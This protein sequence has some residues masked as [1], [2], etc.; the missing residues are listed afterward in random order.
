VSRLTEERILLD[1]ARQALI[2]GEPERSLG[3]LD[4]HRTRFTDG[5]LAEERDAM[6]VEALVRA[7]RYDDARK[8][9]GDFRSRLP[10]SLFLPTVESA[11]ASIP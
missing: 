11:I 1:E 6:Q 7:G 3:R 8:R 2:Q 10:G 9:A 5:L 4:L